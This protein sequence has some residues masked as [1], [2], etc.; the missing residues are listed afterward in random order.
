[1]KR[2]LI[3][4]GGNTRKRGY[5][6]DKKKKRKRKTSFLSFISFFFLIRPVAH[7]FLYVLLLLLL[8]L[9]FRLAFIYFLRVSTK[10]PPPTLG[11]SAGAKGARVHLRR[12]KKKASRE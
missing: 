7:F 5:L 6:L 9:L 1:V 12:E 2:T 11:Q 10:C 3:Y 4:T 8:L